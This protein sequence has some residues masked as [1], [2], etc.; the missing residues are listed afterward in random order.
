MYTDLVEH[1]AHD[2]RVIALD[3]PGTGM[4]DSAPANFRVQ[5]YGHTVIDALDVLG[6]EQFALYGLHGGNKVA[7]SIAVRNP[8]R[9]LGLV[10]AGQSH[11]IIAPYE[12]R[13]QA[14][15]QTPAVAHVVSA[16]DL[17]SGSPLLWSRQFRDLASIWWEDSVVNAHTLA[18]QTRAVDSARE[19]LETFLHKPQFYKAIDEYDLE[20]E[21]A[22]LQVPTLIL[23][24]V[25]PKEDLAIGRQGHDLLR[26]ISGS[27][28]HEMEIEDSDVV[29]LEDRAVEVSVLIRDFVTSLSSPAPPP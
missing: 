6:I 21:F 17:A 18:V 25:S 3:L 8:A 23:E 12:Q 26:R 13:A 16:E 28:L 29:T 4:S 7:T 22:K 2:M 19:S 9:V 14:F 5:D 27:T 24:L 20:H 10:I 1:L 11:S 15:S